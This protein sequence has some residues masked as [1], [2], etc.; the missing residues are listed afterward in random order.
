MKTIKAVIGANFGDEGKGLMTDYFANK[1]DD[2]IVVRFN[3]GAQAGH[4]VTTPDGKRHVFGHVGSGTLAGLPTYLSSFFVV[5]PM[6]FK[7]ETGLLSSMGVT[8]KVYID[9]QCMVTTPY[10]MMINQI[11]EISRGSS[12][13]GSCGVGF[14]ETITRSLSGEQFRLSFADLA[15]RKQV[16]ERL[17]AIQ[18]NYIPERIRELEIGEIPP[19]YR[20]LLGDERIIDSYRMDI[21]TMLDRVEV[22]EVSCLRKYDSLLFEGAQG[23]LLDQS[24]PYFPHVTRSNTGIQN[25]ADLLRQA[26]LSEETMEIVYV[27]RAYLTR[28]G[29]GPFPTEL[30]EKPYPRIEDLTNVPNPYQDVLRYGLLDLNQLAESIRRDWQHAS[31][32]KYRLSLAITCLDQLDGQV[33]YIE[34]C[35]PVRTGLELFVRRILAKTGVR[36]GY[37]S[38]GPVRDQVGRLKFDSLKKKNDFPEIYFNSKEVFRKN[39]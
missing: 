30:P 33:D 29:A 35:L 3:G 4:T 36:N 17:L 12:K 37:T 39:I 28:H 31:N 11:A 5:N 25:V 22:G 23:L 16:R 19:Q 8:S 24:H 10:D 27:T 26:G 15:N 20:E 34:D 9:S 38:Y 14:N 7:K 2:G 18:K 32:F 6:L 1:L 21:D 13:H